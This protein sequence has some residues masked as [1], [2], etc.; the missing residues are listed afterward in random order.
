MKFWCSGIQFEKS[1]ETAGHFVVVASYDFTLFIHFM[2]TYGWVV[3]VCTRPSM[4]YADSAKL[5]CR[6]GTYEL[7]VVSK[8]HSKFLY[9]KHGRSIK[10]SLKPTPNIL[11]QKWLPVNLRYFGSTYFQ[12]WFKQF[13]EH[14]NIWTFNMWYK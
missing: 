5:I 13:Y 7:K 12:T 14:N 9:P 11:G 2:S 1:I 8:S 3:Y 10:A 4:Y 6:L